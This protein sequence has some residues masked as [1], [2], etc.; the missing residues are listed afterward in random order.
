M[1]MT[2]RDIIKAALRELKV[3]P[4]G[5]EPE[6]DELADGMT[7][8]TAMLRSWQTFANL[9]RD[10]TTEVVITALVADVPLPDDVRT[11]T[12]VRVVDGYERPLS[13][14]D[15]G[16]YHTVPN[17]AQIGRPLAYTERR[18]R[19]ST[20][21]TLWPIP[22]TVV[23]LMVDYQRRFETIT[24]PAASLDI[25]EDWE[26]AVWA[27]LAVRLANSFGASADLTPELVDRAGSLLR[28]LRDD[29][30]PSSYYM[31]AEGYA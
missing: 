31:G 3:L 27:N 10:E 28:A 14:W 17:K 18:G 29:D 21:L 20:S 25:P 23:T 26:E 4:S 16:D 24:E 19:D 11:V 15:V 9:W 12:A 5:G 13:P 30:R 2:A 6:A 7:G 22:S 8:L 1:A